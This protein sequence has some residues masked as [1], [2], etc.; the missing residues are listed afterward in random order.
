VQIHLETLGR[1]TLEGDDGRS[2]TRT[3]DLLL[4]REAL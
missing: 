2:W 3:R 1:Q 4:I